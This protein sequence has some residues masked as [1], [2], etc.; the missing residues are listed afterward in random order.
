VTARTEPAPPPRRERRRKR[1]GSRR[2][3]RERLAF[4]IIAGLLLGGLVSAWAFSIDAAYRERA[5]PGKPGLA[6]APP[7]PRPA[8]PPESRASV[9]RTIGA[10]LT[11]PRASSTA[12][13]SDAAM[14][15]LL[16]E[17]RGQSGKLK[18]VIRAP[19]ADLADEADPT[20]SATFEGPAGREVSSPKLAAPADPGIYKLAVQ[21]GKISRP[22][23]DLRVITMVPFAQKKN[24]R[25]GLY[26]LGSWPYESGGKPRTA[27]YANPS[28]FIEVTRENRTTAVSEHFK[29]GDFLTKDQYDVWPKYLLL[30]PKLLDKLELT[31]AELEKEGH[32]V[33]HVFVMSGFRTPRYNKG[34][35]N[36][37][38]RANLSRHMYGDASDVY[39]D[40][41]RDGQ[42]DDLNG[43]GR[44]DTK[45]AKIFADAAE[46]VEREYPALVGGIGIYKACCGHGPFTHIDTRGYRARWYGEGAG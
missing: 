29:L 8:A 38:G 9:A 28:G 25:I 10:S 6:A 20:L 34:G 32:R 17:M 26:Y 11:D 3:P 31:V 23:E 15:A 22:V 4:D 35:G 36:T 27:S 39:I 42:P 2:S 19:N 5:Q 14:N 30:E 13:L 12:Y 41:D 21:L 37:G 18:A 40:N 7:R 16:Q 43:D 1:W 24:D 33:D 45:D 46:K 44:V